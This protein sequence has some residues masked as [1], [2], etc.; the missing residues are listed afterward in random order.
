MWQRQERVRA[1][2]IFN[3]Y[4]RIVSNQLNLSVNYVFE[5]NQYQIYK[6]IFYWKL[7]NK[8]PMKDEP[9]LLLSNSDINTI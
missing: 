7:E 6:L 3:E 4:F 1:S 5:C 9:I 2:S 8:S